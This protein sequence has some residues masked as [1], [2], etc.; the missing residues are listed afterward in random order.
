MKQYKYNEDMA[1]NHSW[2]QNMVKREQE[3]F[4]EYAQRWR[5]LVAQV[6]PQITK[7]EMVTMFID[8]LL[9]L[10]YDK[11]VGSVTSNFTYLVVVGKRIELGNRR[12]KLANPVPCRNR[13]DGCP[14]FTDAICPSLSAMSR[15]KSSCYF[16]VSIE[17]R[18]KTIQNA[19]PNPHDLYKIAPSI[20]GA[21][22]RGDSAPQAPSSPVSEK[23]R[24]Q[25]QNQGSNVQS[26]P[27]SAHKGA[28]VN[29]LTH[30]NRERVESPNKQGGSLMARPRQ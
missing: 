15:R 21:E 17:R 25:R 29:A 23:L 26:N 18:K 24:P 11:V 5:E 1:P 22:A 8:T 6:Q 3:G 4:K 9:S 20:V 19:D 13:I 14:L 28:T 27:L 7:R 12:G 10:Y 16:K 2:L 30:E